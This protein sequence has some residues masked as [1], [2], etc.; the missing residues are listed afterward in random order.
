MTLLWVM[1][2]GA[3]GSMLRLGVDRGIERSFHRSTVAGIVVVNLVGSFVLGCVVGAFVHGLKTTPLSGMSPTTYVVL[4]AGFCGGFTTFS[5]AM[6]DTL[7]LLRMGRTGP[8]LTHLLVTFVGAVVC[9][10][11]GYAF[12]A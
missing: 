5:T 9:C 1:A 8:A 3:L 2:A 10:Q 7:R 4:A 6:A 12:F 11:L